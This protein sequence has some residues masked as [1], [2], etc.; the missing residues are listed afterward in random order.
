MLTP[1]QG[2]FGES[3]VGG[4]AVANE[5]EHE[6]DELI[7]NEQFYADFHAIALTQC[8]IQRASIPFCLIHCMTLH[9]SLGNYRTARGG[10]RKT[11][12]GGS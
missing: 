2:C 4:R 5:L 10:S 12:R 1:I 11:P 3:S 6:G 7:S 9:V 8:S